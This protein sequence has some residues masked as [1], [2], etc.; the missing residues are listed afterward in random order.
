F[1]LKQTKQ[2]FSKAELID[3]AEEHPERFSPNVVLRPL[4][5]DHVLPTLA[6]IAG[7]AE[8]AYFAQ[9]KTNYYFFET[10]MPL[11]VPRACMTLVESKVSKVFEKVGL[12]YKEFFAE[13]DAA[14]KR[15]IAAASDANLEVLFERN[16]TAVKT[17]LAELETALKQLDPTL[18]ESLQT[19]SGKIT[20][21]LSGIREKA[22]RAEKQKSS[23][24]IAQLDKCA[25]HLFPSGELQERTL[26]IF[27]FL[28]K[29]GFGF[30]GELRQT[31]ATS[32]RGTHLIA[33]L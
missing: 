11:I 33:E 23:E 31:I 1:E 19:A 30:I 6:Y 12:S 2:T 27:Y 3:Q 32:E 10:E 13:R 16:E 9:F 29:Y 20:H 14:T 18:G 7:P 25:E 21:V 28:N 17:A 15:L 26:N 4:V 5:Q 22:A 8:A 24:L